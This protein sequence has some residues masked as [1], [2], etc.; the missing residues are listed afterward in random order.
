MKEVVTLGQTVDNFFEFVI[1][2]VAISCV[3]L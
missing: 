2:P 1:F 3:L